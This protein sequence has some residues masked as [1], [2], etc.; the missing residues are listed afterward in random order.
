MLFTCLLL[1]SHK[2]PAGG[3]KGPAWMPMLPDDAY[4]VLTERSIQA[5]E[6]AA[7]SD[8]KNA[9]DLIE[10][11]AAVLAGYTL[12]IKEAKGDA[13]ST[14]RGAAMQATVAARA[15]DLAK[16]KD[17]KKSIAAAPKAPAEMKDVKTYLHATEPMM[18]AFLS[19]AKGGEGIHTDLQYQPKL[20]NLNGI[21]ALISTLASK[22]ISDDNLAKVAKEL[23]LLAYRIS[24]MGSLTSHFAPEKD[25]NKWREY[26]GEMR[27]HAMNLAAET[28]KKNSDGVMK[29][30]LKLESSCIDCHSVFKNN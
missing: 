25:A 7:K 26:A 2:V 15:K 8:A 14:L 30:A 18:K 19:K 13:A 24:I 28:N 22:K 6:D 29:A 23:P 4:K 17:F 20:K 12:S 9:A 11:E 1:T 16:L 21:E 10:I 3:G 27:D 5:I